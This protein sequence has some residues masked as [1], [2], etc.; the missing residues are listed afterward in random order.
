MTSF[1]PMEKPPK[2]VSPSP[3]RLARFARSL[4]QWALIAVGIVVV[5][6]VAG[7]LRAP[8]LPDVA[9]DFSLRSLSGEPIALAGLRGR[10]VLLN[11]WASWCGPCRFELPALR[12]FAEARPDVAVLGV[13]HD[14]PGDLRATAAE[15]GTPYPILL[16]FDGSISER[17]GVKTLPT[18]VA[19]DA[20]G[21]VIWSYTGVLLDPQL[22]WLRLFL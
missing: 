6:Y 9:P 7:R 19:I 16:D 18:T 22:A 13:A 2:A 12:R 8:D 21:R 17:Y 4:G 15:A 5:G 20:D 1:A 14:E 10:P 11:F 3:S